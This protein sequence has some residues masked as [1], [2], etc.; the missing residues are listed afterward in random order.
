MRVVS[1]EFDCRRPRGMYGAGLLRKDSSG[2][3]VV[4]SFIGLLA[5]FALLCSALLC[6]A[7]LAAGASKGEYLQGF[8]A[9]IFR[10]PFGQ[11]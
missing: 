4:C 6:F 8:P 1:R 7:L 3:G 9:V 11:L 10:L 5:V 2:C